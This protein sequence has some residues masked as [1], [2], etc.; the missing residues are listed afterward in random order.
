MRGLKDL[1]RL[2]ALLAAPLLCGAAAA[3]LLPP[4]SGPVGGVVGEVDRLGTGLTDRTLGTA[5]GAAR[6]A[7]ERLDRF[8]RMVRAA[9]EQLEMTALGPAVRGEIVAADPSPEALAAAHDAGFETVRVEEIES[10]G[11][12]TVTLRAP[13]GLSLDKALD[14]LRLLAPRSEFSANHLHFRS[15]AAP[16]GATGNAML[17]RAG[18]AGSIV[19]GIIDGGVAAHA[20]PPHAAPHRPRFRACGP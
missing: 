3:Q 8:R 18:A 11:M 17:A 4:L 13:G 10:L 9:P 5:A 1:A 20:V 14:R 12:R 6:L 7:E 16:A 15:G 2:A 19:V